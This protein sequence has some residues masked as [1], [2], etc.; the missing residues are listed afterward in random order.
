MDPTSRF[1]FLV[2]A[3]TAL[4][5]NASNARAQP[6]NDDCTSAELISITSGSAGSI[7]GDNTT[8]LDDPGQPACL[9]S[10]S[11]ASGTKGVWY[12]FVGTG[13]RVSF[14]SCSGPTDLTMRVYC[15]GC[16]QP[17]CA[18]S[19]DDGCDVNSL[20][21]RLQLCTSLGTQYLLLVSRFGTGTSAAFTLNWSDSGT[22]CSAAGFPSCVPTTP[23]ND[24]CAG[25]IPLSMGTTVLGT[26]IDASAES[27]VPPTCNGIAVGN[28]VWY[29]FV[30]NGMTVTASTCSA[31]T[32]SNTRVSILTGSCGSFTCVAGNSTA[33]PACS[34]RGD[35]GSA[36]GLCTTSGQTYYVVVSSDTNGAGLFELS[37]TG[38]N[39]GCVPPANDDCAAAIGISSF[40]FTDSPA[41]TVA[42]ADLDVSCNTA[43]NFSSRAGVWYRFTPSEPGSVTFTETGTADVVFTVFTTP[44][45]CTALSEV[46]CN[47]NE[48][49]TAPFA[50]SAN[51]TYYILVSMASDTAALPATYI[52]SIGFTPAAGACCVG[53]NC[54]VTNGIAGCNA[55][56]GAFQGYGVSCG[57]GP[58]PENTNPTPVAIPDFPTGGPVST[59]SS[60]VTLTS[61][62]VITD[63]DVYVT[64]NHTFA[65]DIYLRLRGPNGTIIDLLKRPNVAAP[66]TAGAIGNGN[67]LVGTYAFD[68]DAAQTLHA[69]VVA[70]PSPIASGHY[71]PATCTGTVTSLDAASPAGFGGISAAGTWTL[72][73]SDED[74]ALVGT[75]ESFGLVINGVQ[76]NTPCS[77]STT[78]ACCQG[79]SCVIGSAATCVGA[80]QSYA[81]NG[82]AC[83][84]SGN[85]TMPCCKADFN[86][87]GG[88]TVQDIFDFLNAYF[89]A[90]PFA[91]VN[92]GGTSVQD[93]FDFIN[94]YFAGNC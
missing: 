75:L 85:L 42:G 61:P 9:L 44:T 93:I 41:V 77:V 58:L 53:S 25:A 81:G 88:I 73:V 82:T 38:S 69:A 27:V 39:A 37:L 56:G 13:N 23:A 6:A 57:G 43:A 84:V 49:G 3:L 54:V 20:G 76:A 40:P 34:S 63:L 51:T 12:A 80:N 18:A 52:I 68:D 5:C 59:V 78:G 8:A 65:G 66:C 11:A 60:S 90:D 70:G 94:A 24:E 35:S 15:G 14:D 47:T 92:G 64:I 91:D 55:Q 72:Q 89:A 74:E 71:Q 36:V 4:L 86:Q 29:S 7:A 62:E 79:S 50:A 10:T 17:V 83:N 67:D 28:G 22:P 16:A 2:S 31:A 30:G 46:Y 33:T 19:D 21:S 32:G 87:V 48:A 26:T 45:D 1:R